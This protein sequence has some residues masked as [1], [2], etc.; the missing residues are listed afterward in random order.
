M[1]GGITDEEALELL[2]TIRSLAEAAGRDPDSIGTMLQL[3]PPP[4]T[5]EDKRFYADLDR[6]E[7]RA[8]V[9]AALGFDWAAV[10]ATAIFQAGARSVDA[11]IEQLD[12]IHT[13]I[14]RSTG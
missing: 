13:R 11:I 10:N 3:A 9:I 4:R 2:A 6:V 8:A 12:E 1:A 7:E 14:R 5:E